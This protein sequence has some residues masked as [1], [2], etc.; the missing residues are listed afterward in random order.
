[1]PATSSVSLSGNLDIDGLLSGVRWLSPDLTF[2][3]PTA[4]TQYGYAETGFEAMNAAQMAAIRAILQAYASVADLSF[5]EVAESSTTHGTIRF[6]E[7]DNAGTAYAYYPSA[8]EQGGDVWANHTDYNTPLPGTY[9]FATFLHEIGH[10]LG[11]DHGQDGIAAL[12]TDHDSLEYSVMTYRSFVGADLNGYTVQQGS[13][14]TTPMLDDVA[15]LQYMYGANYD[16]R[17]GDTVYSWS[18]TTGELSVDGAGQGAAT[19]N[20]VFMTIWDG[21]GEDTYDF[22]AYATGLTVDL[23]PGAW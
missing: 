1:M 13:F 16:T 2:S 23:N 19:A 17:A 11:L 12:P 5:T 14:P 22:S 15:A 6:A 4:L 20:K 9:A 10:T 21:G 7:E 8:A 18:P 3:F